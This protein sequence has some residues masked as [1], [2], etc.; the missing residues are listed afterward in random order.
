[1]S[2]YAK[3]IAEAVIEAAAKVCDQKL[4]LRT[5]TGHPR[6]ASTARS[7][8]T[9]IRSLDRDAII[10]SVPQ[11][12]DSRDAERWRHVVD[13]AISTATNQSIDPDEVVLVVPAAWGDDWRERAAAHVDAAIAQ[14]K[15]PK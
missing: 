2:D 9:E 5:A 10:A 12:E 4:A 8:A 15:E 1:M 7:L 14:G 6:E 13:E 3:R 11:S